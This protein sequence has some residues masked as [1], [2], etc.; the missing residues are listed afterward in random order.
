M[1]GYKWRLSTGIQVSYTQMSASHQFKNVTDQPTDST[2]IG[3][4]T[5]IRRT[6]VRATGVSWHHG[7]P[8][9]GKVDTTWTLQYNCIKRFKRSPQFGSHYA[10]KRQW[11]PRIYFSSMKNACPYVQY[12]KSGRLHPLPA[13]VIHLFL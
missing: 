12:R 10:E 5:A 7:D 13:L 4:T 6:A 8:I 9:E 1:I 3:K 2:H 11:N